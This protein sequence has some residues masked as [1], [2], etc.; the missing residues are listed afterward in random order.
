MKRLNIAL[1]FL[2]CAASAPFALIGASGQDASSL[3]EY[4]PA[5]SVSGLLRSWGSDQMGTL[6]KYWE[7]GFRKYQPNICFFD[8]LKGTATAQFG[9]HEW[10]ADLAVTTRKIYPYEFYGVYR[11]SLLYPVEIAVATGSYDVPR[12]SFALVVFVH[13]DNPLSKL[14]LKQLDGMYG[15][16]RT[17]GWQDLNWRTEVARNS[18]EDIRTWGQLGLTGTWAHKPIHVYG[19][20]G[21]YPGGISFFQMRVFG[22]ADSWNEALQEFADPKKMMATLGKDPYGI[23]YTGMCYRTPDVKPLALADK[24]GQTYVQP[25]RSTVADRTYPLSRLAYI[26]FAPDRPNGE[27]ASPKVDPKI[28]EFLRYVL[29][30]QGQADVIQEGDYLPLTAPLARE[31]LRKLE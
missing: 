10:I 21:I 7:Q 15:A 22:G 12:K 27:A 23:A 2:L 1:W 20:P 26:Y 6:L 3:P 11:R 30:R 25:A 8:T 5:E 17:G 29:S 18:S 28:R 9:L 4:T 13:K 16:H 31:Q 14:T 19:Q 24:P